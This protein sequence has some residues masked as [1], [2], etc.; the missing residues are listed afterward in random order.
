MGENFQRIQGKMTF[1][2]IHASNPLPF[3]TM[4]DMIPSGPP[5]QGS[6]RGGGGG[7]QEGNKV[8]RGKE[9][10]SR[11]KVENIHKINFQ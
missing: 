2:I 3:S 6:H 1:E 5:G 8:R 4:G 9:G 7:A 11:K 10:H